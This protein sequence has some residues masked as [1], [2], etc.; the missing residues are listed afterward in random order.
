MPRRELDPKNLR[1]DEDWEGNNAA[2]AC[3]L[4]KKVFIVSSQIHKGIRRCP[5]CQKAMG[6]CEG[7]KESGG[8]ASIEWGGCTN[9]WCPAQ[10]LKNLYERCVAIWNLFGPIVK[11]ALIGFVGLLLVNGVVIPTAQYRQIRLEKQYKALTDVATINGRYYQS[12]WNVY[13]GKEIP[14]EVEAR[15]QYRDQAQAVSVEAERVRV[16]LSLLFRDP[17]IS[18]EWAQLANT[19]WAAYYPIGQGGKKLPTQEELEAKLSQTRPRL[20]SLIAKMRREMGY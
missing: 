3:P 4:C 6:S 20:G 7:G 15:R 5:N 16:E 9:P 10:L 17:T 18:E 8:K 14:E 19:Y 12:V 13:F 1:H 2:F 11:S